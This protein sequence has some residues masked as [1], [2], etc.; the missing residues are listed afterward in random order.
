MM[1]WGKRD[2]DQTRQEMRDDSN[3]CVVLDCQTPLSLLFPDVQLSLVCK[4][5]MPL[6]SC[7]AQGVALQ[8][9]DLYNR[10]VL[11]SEAENG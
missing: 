8:R 5:K 3:D 11:N 4:R 6:L 9:D 7:A 2:H 10:S 1:L